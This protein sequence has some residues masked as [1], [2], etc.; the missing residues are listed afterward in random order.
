MADHLLTDLYPEIRRFVKNC[1]DLTINY[2]LIRAQRIFCRETNFYQTTLNLPLVNDLD[3]YQLD[4]NQ[5]DEVIYIKDVMYN[6]RPLQSQRAAD[7]WITQTGDMPFVYIY[8][9]PDLLML[10]PIP[11][12]V[13]GVPGGGTTNYPVPQTN[14]TVHISDSMPDICLVRLVLQPKESSTIMPDVIYRDYKEAVCAGASAWILQQPQEVWSNPQLGVQM[15]ST[16]QYGI[17]EAKR[18]RL[19]GHTSGQV[20]IRPRSFLFN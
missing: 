19:F 10:R 3:V 6:N 7:V 16:F 12:N 11:H 17:N 15:Q 8:E 4:L 14:Q 13:S 1:P 18:R 20:K 5:N 2:A 9:P